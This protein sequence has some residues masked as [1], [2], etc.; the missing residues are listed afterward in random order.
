MSTAERVAGT[1]TL[2]VDL[3]STASKL[4]SLR[5]QRQLS[6]EKIEEATGVKAGTLKNWELGQFG[7]KGPAAVDLARLARFYKVSTDWLFGLADDP[8]VL[9]AGHT[10]VDRGLVQRIRAAKTLADLADDE[11]P[12]SIPYAVDIPELRS[13]HPPRD[14]QFEELREEIEEKL[15]Q[16]RGKKGS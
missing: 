7:N 3:A 16:L 1:L 14:P 6:R 15:R 12:E 5:A 9:P 11:V 2:M 10:L 4:R 13:L 8:I